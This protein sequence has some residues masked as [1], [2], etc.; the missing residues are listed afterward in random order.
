[1]ESRKQ[2][3][4]LLLL[5][6]Y[7]LWFTSDGLRSYFSYDD[8]M[9][10]YCGW[11]TP[12]ATVLQA[13]FLVPTGCERPLGALFYRAVYA[14]FGFSPLAFRVPVFLLLLTN[15]W[16]TYKIAIRLTRS[17]ETAAVTALLAAV[18]TGFAPLYYDTGVVYD[19]MC[20][21]FYFLAFLYVIRIR[22]EGGVLGARQLIVLIVLCACA[23]N[24]KELGATLPL[25]FL[26]YEL[27]YQPPTRWSISALWKWSIR[28]G[29]AVWVTGLEV[30][31]FIVGKLL[32]PSTLVQQDTY[33]PLF[34]WARFTES[35]GRF[36]NDLF[37]LRG[38]FTPV[39]IVAMWLVALV[40]AG[41]LRTKAARFA[42]LFLMFTPLPV[43]FIS[44]RDAHSYYVPLFGWA[45][46]AASL[47]AAVAGPLTRRLPGSL[48]ISVSILLV[49]LHLSTALPPWLDSTNPQC[50][51]ASVA[52]QLLTLYPRLTPGSRLLFASDPF[53]DMMDHQGMYLVRLMYG[54]S[55][56][57]VHRGRGT[58]PDSLSDGRPYD[59]VF[60]WRDGR[61]IELPPRA[62]P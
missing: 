44:P 61:L 22:G 19:V 26:I 5:G 28:E 49:P 7:F 31:W 57:V 41:C 2:P 1:M 13:N 47:L 10:L 53:P 46:L 48:F 60:E 3:P 25:A 33:R 45:L 50:A 32:G 29:R 39:S 55:S 21:T 35:W 16:L 56:L 18:H 59:H 54:D 42:W 58:A 6:V 12:L 51:I 30:S 23:I 43:L 52:R 62:R 34:T 11:V 17:T 4:Y 20:Y 15:I 37:Y 38:W 40:V 14:L 27:V 24:S 36:L 9:N 8:L